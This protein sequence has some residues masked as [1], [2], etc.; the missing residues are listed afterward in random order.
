[1]STTKYGLTEKEFELCNKIGA[2]WI[3]RNTLINE[4]HVSFWDGDSK[5]ITSEAG[6][7]YT[8]DALTTQ[9]IG[10]LSSDLFPSVHPGDCICIDEA[11]EQNETCVRIILKNGGEFTM[12]CDGVEIEYDE[13]TNELLRIKYSK[14]THNCPLYLKL[15]DVSAVVKL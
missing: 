13:A 12:I 3:T 7:F 9:R 1:M 14:G 8:K 5:P 6:V 11:E 4:N 10:Y 15:D 2:K